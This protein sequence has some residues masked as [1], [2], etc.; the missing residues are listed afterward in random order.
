MDKALFERLTN[1]SE[2]FSLQQS[3]TD[4]INRILCCG[5]FL[6]AT[7]GQSVDAGREAMDSIFRNSMPSIVDQS[8]GNEEQQSIYRARLAKLLLRFEPRLKSV[9]V[10]SLSQVGLR[11][12]CRLKIELIDGE[13]EQEFVFGNV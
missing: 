10:N 4:N 9:K 8:F 13:F 5:G 2:D 3:V 6:D 11:S 12:S 7:T 1:V